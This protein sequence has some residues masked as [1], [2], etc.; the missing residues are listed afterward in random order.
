MGGK[1]RD[2]G[3]QERVD[4]EVHEAADRVGAQKSQPLGAECVM[5]ALVAEGKD[6]VQ[7]P[8]KRRGAQERDDSP[9]VRPRTRQAQHQSQHAGIDH[10][11]GDADRAEGEELADYLSEPVRQGASASWLATEVKRIGMLK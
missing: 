11:A 8:G 4:A 7:R 2:G 1:E 5:S 6:P 9:Q 10:E 3:E